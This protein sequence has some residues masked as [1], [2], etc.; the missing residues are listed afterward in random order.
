[1]SLEFVPQAPERFDGNSACASS[2]EA[3]GASAKTPAS[4]AGPS[5][6]TSSAG[7][8]QASSG[9]GSSCNTLATTTTTDGGCNDSDDG[10]SGSSTGNGATTDYF[11]GSTNGGSGGDGSRNGSDTHRTADGNVA[12]ARQNGGGGNHDGPNDGGNGNVPPGEP[13]PRRRVTFEDGM[14][15]VY[16][17]ASRPFRRP[18]GLSVSALLL[19]SLWV[20]AVLAMLLLHFLPASAEGTRSREWREGA[21]TAMGLSLVLLTFATSFYVVHSCLLQRRRAQY[22]EPNEASA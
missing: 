21:L 17:F 13:A 19:A 6:A 4:S 18:C 2:T 14:P 16:S 3:C 15:V 20:A 9:D 12:T 11:T 7:P 1:M 5:Q 8:P 22:V 10:S